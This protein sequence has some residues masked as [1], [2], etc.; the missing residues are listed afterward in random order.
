M[1]TKTS[2]Q[3]MEEA[4]IDIAV[5]NIGGLSG[6]DAPKMTVKVTG[7][8]PA[9]IYDAVSGEPSKVPLNMVKSR[10]KLRRK[11]E[12]DKGKPVFTLDKPQRE[13]S[14]PNCPCLLH[15]DSPQRK[16][17]DEMFLPV[18]SAILANPYEVERHMKIYH[19]TAYNQI[20]KER[21]DIKEAEDRAFQRNILEMA[22]GNKEPTKRGR[23]GRKQEGT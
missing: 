9:T 4:E 20:E 15:A 14:K 23:K 7:N 3:I 5:A 2:E 11:E 16:H 19:P 17:F 1:V 12:P 18:C 10:L 13:P 21:K 6:E 8:S 22:S